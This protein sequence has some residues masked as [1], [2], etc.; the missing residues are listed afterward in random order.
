MAFFATLRADMPL[1]VLMEPFFLS[2]SRVARYTLSLNEEIPASI[3]L[4][5]ISANF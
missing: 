3:L 1:I 4:K 2:F 5:F